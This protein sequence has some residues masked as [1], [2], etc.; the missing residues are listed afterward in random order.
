MLRMVSYGDFELVKRS[1]MFDCCYGYLDSENFGSFSVCVC[2]KF[3][4][5]CCV[6]L[7]CRCVRSRGMKQGF[8]V[9]PTLIAQ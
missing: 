8:E 5:N 3:M 4:K 7:L 1:Y 6:V 9:Q 2:V